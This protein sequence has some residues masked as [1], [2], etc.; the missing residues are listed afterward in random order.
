EPGSVSL[1]HLHRDIGSRV[2]GPDQENASGT[3]L[4]GIAVFAGVHLHDPRV[5][6][7]SEGGDRRRPVEAGGHDHVL[8]LVPVLAAFDDVAVAVLGEPVDGHPGTNRKLEARRIGLEVVGGLA[9][10]RIRPAG[11]RERPARQAVVARGRE[12]A[13]RVPST[14]P[15]RAADPLARVEDH[16]R[17]AAP[18]QVVA[19][20]EAGLAAADDDRVELLA[21]RDAAATA[22]ERCFL[23]RH[24]RSSWGRMSCTPTVGRYGCGRI[25]RIHQLAA[26]RG[27]S[28]LT[29]RPAQTSSCS[30]ANAPAAVRDETPSLVKMFWTCRATVC[31]LITSAAAISRLLFPVAS[32]RST[33]SSLAV[34]PWAAATGSVSESREARSGV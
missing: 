32:R 34:N 29:T 25:A 3:E 7:G 27:W 5:E 16:E 2:S 24:D 13:E 15:P 1:G 8:G 33:S 31:S 17:A 26:G 19:D 28:F 4:G 20:R 21:G 30:K 22:A 18:L 6:L 10:G 12:Q 11:R 23:C 9:R 14:R